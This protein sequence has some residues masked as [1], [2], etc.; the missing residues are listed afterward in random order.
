MDPS[1]NAVGRPIDRQA[2][3]SGDVGRKTDPHGKG[4]PGPDACE[5]GRSAVIEM[6]HGFRRR[7][8]ERGAAPRRA[9]PAYPTRI[10]VRIPAAAC[11]SMWQCSNQSPGLSATNAMSAVSPRSTRMVSRNGPTPPSAPT[12]P[13]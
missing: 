11:P 8:G 12:V 5:T 9:E 2:E 1:G 6:P 3:Y 7:A 4:R 10:Q 13:K